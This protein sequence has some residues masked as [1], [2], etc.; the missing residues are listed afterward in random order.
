MLIGKLNRGISVVD[1][2]KLLKE[3]NELTDDEFFLSSTLGWCIEWVKNIFYIYFFIYDHIVFEQ[4][5]YKWLCFILRQ[6]DFEP[7]SICNI[8]SSKHIFSSLT[9]SWTT[10][11]LGEVSLAGSDSLRLVSSFFLIFSGLWDPNF[12]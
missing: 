7:F 5:T 8:F 6:T 3:R 11:T 4:L 12:L 1:S 9:I 2:Y 10:P